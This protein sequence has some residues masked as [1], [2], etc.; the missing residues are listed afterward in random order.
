MKTSTT[1]LIEALEI[2][3]RDI[4]SEDGIANSAIA[5][6]A[7]RMKKMRKNI[8][9]LLDLAEDWGLYGPCVKEAKEL[10]K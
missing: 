7:R 10:I 6:A 1:T 2:L 8:E 9:D 4:E 5:D 3:S